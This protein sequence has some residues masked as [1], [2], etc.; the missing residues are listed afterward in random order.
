MPD[1]GWENPV[2]NQKSKKMK[3]LITLL[4][5]LSGSTTLSAQ[6]YPEPEFTNE[7]CY[8][9]KG[10]SAT[11]VRLEKGNSRMDT[12]VK[13]AGFGG[14]ESGY[15][16]EGEQSTT[17]LNV[18]KG[19]SFILYTGEGEQKKS[20][21][22]DSM[23]KANGVDPAAME[24]MG[25]SGDPSRNISLYKMTVSQGSR[26]IFLQKSGGMFSMKKN[27]S[28][29]KIPFSVRKIR[30]GYWELLTDKGLSGGEYAFTFMGA[31]SMDGSV[32]L[33]AFGIN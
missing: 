1:G 17:R 19:T 6:Q 22:M 21:Y 7:I 33:F 12:K 27:G 18:P 31:G 16:L 2:T 8:L 25:M 14:A 28:S 4:L 26:K 10:D 11:L 9:V 5:L 20:A 23:M 24:A 15:T 32:M 30:E 3:T 29:D 13:M